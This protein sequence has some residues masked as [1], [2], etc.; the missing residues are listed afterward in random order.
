MIRVNLLVP[1]QAPK[2]VW[3]AQERR[4]ALLGAVMF[5]CTLA[6]VGGWWMRLDRQTVVVEAEIAAGEQELAQLQ[7]A[8]RL[9]DRAVARRQE[10]FE[11]LALIERLRGAQ[12]GPVTL[13]ST[14]SR[15]LPDGLWLMELNQRG[16]AVQ[17]EG[18]ATSLTAVT[19]FAERLQNSGSFEWPV[20]IVTTSLELVEETSVVRFALRAQALGKGD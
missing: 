4:P 17:I 7:Q 5:L 6:G 14:V 20:D 3:M 2:R 19:D 1:G 8:A 12:R 18:R 16:P 9:V 10:L 13:L 11:E 15:S